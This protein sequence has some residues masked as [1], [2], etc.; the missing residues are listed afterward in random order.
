MLTSFQALPLAFLIEK[1]GGASSD[2]RT[3]LL[4]VRI[5][6]NSGRRRQTKN[7]PKKNQFEKKTPGGV[8]RSVYV[9]MLRKH[10]LKPRAGVASEG[11]ARCV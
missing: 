7:N 2:G 6:K 9:C 3:S 10:A 11:V 4:D 1:C 5:G 8:L